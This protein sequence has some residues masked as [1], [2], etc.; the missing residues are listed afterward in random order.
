M[1]EQ[2]Q[3]K[4]IHRQFS[5]ICL[6]WNLWIFSRC[7]LSAFHQILAVVRGAWAIKYAHYEKL[8]YPAVYRTSVGLSQQFEPRPIYL[9]AIATSA[10]SPSS[11]VQLKSAVDACMPQNFNKIQLC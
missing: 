9:P 8:F 4:A 2:R 11:R 1:Q 5:Y 6:P 10:F 7:S 3:N